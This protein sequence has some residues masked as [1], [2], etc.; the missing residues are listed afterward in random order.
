MGHP[1]C[2]EFHCTILIP[3]A[4]AQYKRK[5]GPKANGGLCL[6]LLTFVFGFEVTELPADTIARMAQWI[7][8]NTTAEE[9]EEKGGGEQLFISGAD[10]ILTYVNP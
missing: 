5:L 7:E 4:R 8:R 6:D 3:Y 1:D 10:A 9:E 2:P